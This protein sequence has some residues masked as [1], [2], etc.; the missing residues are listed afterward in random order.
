[1]GRIDLRASFCVRPDAASPRHADGFAIFRRYP[2]NRAEP[3]D[4]REHF[5]AHRFFGERFDV[6]DELIARVDV[7]A[8]I[9]IG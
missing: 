9:A 7:D 2:E 8:R 1:M 6:V 5:R 4:A 3:A